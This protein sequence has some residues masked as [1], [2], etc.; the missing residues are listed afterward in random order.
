MRECQKAYLHTPV[1]WLEVRGG[2]A[3]VSAVSFARG[4][5]R[6]AASRGPLP[7]PIARAV[8][9][10]EEY[11]RG[12]RR[13]FT[14]KLDLDG[15][16]PFQRKVWKA[17]KAVP[18]GATASYQ[19]IAKAVGR[20]KAARAVGGANHRNP[21]AIIVPCHRVVG[22][23]GRLTGYG[24]GLWRKR[25]LLDHERRGQEGGCG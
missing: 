13:T 14:V 3:G 5:A 9:E 18:F 17:L 11:F 12:Q 1:G 10:L 15:G 16:T 19:A 24:G 21:I 2:E 25:W 7:R 23:D 8:A 20:P 4:Q 22:S 6:G